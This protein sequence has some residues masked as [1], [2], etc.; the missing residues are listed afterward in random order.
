MISPANTGTH[1]HLNNYRAAPSMIILGG[2]AILVAALAGCS[3]NGHVASAS[4]S[5]TEVLIGGQDQKVRGDVA[6]V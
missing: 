4:A 6:C 5:N 1:K 3:S 2:A